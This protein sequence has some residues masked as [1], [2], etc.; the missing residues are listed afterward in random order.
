MAILIYESADSVEVRNS[1]FGYTDLL[2]DCDSY[3]EL[4]NNIFNAYTY[5]LCGTGS[6]IVDAH[7][8]LFNYSG[9]MWCDDGQLLLGPGNIWDEDPLFCDY[10][11]CDF[12]VDAGSPAVGAGENGETIGAYGVGCGVLSSPIEASL[13]G[14]GRPAP[15]PSSTAVSI[16]V[17][18]DDWQS[19]DVFDP[20][21]RLLRVLV[22]PPVRGGKLSW[23]GLDGRG[24]PVPSG[25][26]MLRLR[27]SRSEVIRSVT[28]VR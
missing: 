11:N 17:I 24:M 15:N 10:S 3:A 26:Y 16:P 7:H 5:V 6:G 4:V 12:R 9:F 2:I 22:D 25:R 19:V 23:D 8:N 21:G 28:I 14:V 27:G 20:R 1:T 13:D 18:G